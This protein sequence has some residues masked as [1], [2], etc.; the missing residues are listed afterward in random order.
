[1]FEFS[2]IEQYH[3]QLQEESFTCLQAVEYYLQK[4]KVNTRLNAFIEVYADEALQKANQLDEKR[5]AGNSL[6][7]LHG[8]VVGLKDVICYKDHKISA[9][10][11]ILKNFISVYSAT[12]VERLLAE[13]AI[14]IGDL[15][16]DEFAMGSTN[17]NSAY[18][19]VLNALDETRVP[20]DRPAGLQWQY[21]QA[22]V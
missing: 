18:G 19:K 21:R 7:K 11:N 14:I 17:E 2:S 15:N 13:D 20:V 3:A 6:G 12:V 10:S 4:I 5:K 22:F 9:S 8:V 1:L 16:C